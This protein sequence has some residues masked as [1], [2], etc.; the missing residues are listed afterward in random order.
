M[1]LVKMTL[2]EAL[3]RPLTVTERAHFAALAAKP[4]AQI[5]FSDQ[6]EITAAAIAVGHVLVTGRG[7]VRTGAGRKSLGKLRKT[8]KLS[9]AAIRR[10]QAYAKRK[11]L[12]DFSAA[13]EAASRTL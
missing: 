1:P 4:D 10:F 7:G 2:A 13:L 5:D 11:R 3:A 9:P 8:V 12:P 6:P